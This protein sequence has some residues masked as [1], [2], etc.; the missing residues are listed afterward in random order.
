MHT[1]LLNEQTIKSILRS[2]GMTLEEQLS[3]KTESAVFKVQRADTCSFVLRLYTQEV[4]ACRA[5]EWHDC[6]GFPQ[7]YRTYSEEGVFVV[8]EEF[9]DGVS[10][11][12]ML[13]G[14]ARM[15]EGRT[16]QIAGKVCEALAFLH[17]K[18]FIHRDVKPEHVFITPDYR[19]VLIDMD[20]SMRLEAGR[21]NDTQLIGTAMYAAPEQFGLTRSDTRTDI[22][23]TGILIN[24]MLTGYHPAVQQYRRGQLGRII[25]KCTKINPDDRYQTI[26]E[27]TDALHDAAGES[28]TGQSRKFRKIILAVTAAICVLTFAFSSGVNDAEELVTPEVP[29]S[30]KN[31]EAEKYNTTT[32]AYAE[33]TDWLQLYKYDWMETTGY[34]HRDGGQHAR[35]YTQDGTLVDNTFDFWIDESIGNVEYWYAAEKGWEIRSIGCEIGA[36]GYIHAQKDDKHYA[37][38]IQVMGESFSVYT[39]LPD[40]RDMT[41]NYVPTYSIDWVQNGYYIDMEYDRN[42]PLTLYLA[43]MRLDD[44]VPSC[45]SEYVEIKPYDGE[46]FWDWPVYEMTFYNPDGGDVILEVESWALDVG[47]TFTEKK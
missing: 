13:E 8:E 30:N 25:E 4:A 44:V 19:I 31:A 43:L 16:L 9:I 47:F 2:G 38:E 1:V 29:V 6:E 34:V 45:R 39:A 12:E 35:Y 27:L 42:E 10:L 23:A 17:D 46:V 28:A 22:Y 15:D 5:M 24:E 3:L 18:G 20:A 7:V 37:M 26:G 41:K 40:L 11:A 32:V 36:T 21:K 14:G 33:G